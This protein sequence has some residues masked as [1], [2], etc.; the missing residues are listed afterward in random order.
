[1]EGKEE[2]DKLKEERKVKG[3]NKRRGRIHRRKVRRSGKE[4]VGRHIRVG[5]GRAE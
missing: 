2:V 4:E 1:M 3:R 5:V